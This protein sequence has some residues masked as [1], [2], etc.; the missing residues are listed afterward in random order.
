[1]RRNSYLDT[2]DNL[3]SAGGVNLR[4]VT[5]VKPA[6]LVYGFSSVLLI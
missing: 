6:F 5:S 2:I 1:M 4:N 3:D